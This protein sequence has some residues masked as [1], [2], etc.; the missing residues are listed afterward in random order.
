MTGVEPDLAV[1]FLG[2]AA[3]LLRSSGG[4]TALIDPYDNE[5]GENPWFVHPMPQ[6]HSDLLVMTHGH[7]DHSA[8]HRTVATET[9]R[10][11]G[12]IARGEIRIRGFGDRHAR[13]DYDNMIVAIEAGAT[14][15]CHIGDNRAEIPAEI[16]DAIGAVDMLAV[17]VDDTRY[18]LEFEDVDR[19]IKAFRPGVVVPIHY[20]QPG[21][22]AETTE[23]GPCDEW[24]ATKPKPRV[25]KISGE[26]SLDR[27]A[28]PDETEVWV[29][30]PM[31]SPSTGAAPA[32]KPAEEPDQENEG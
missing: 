11:P 21:I 2:H 4:T 6:T 1:R 32:E 27:K 17:H 9:L 19:V 7:F 3:F 8:E 18:F 12:E 24:L 20:R 26:V 14:R 29:L 25:K 5:E 23:V 28:F 10:E 13:I 22:S 16:I 31:P 15:F 30:E